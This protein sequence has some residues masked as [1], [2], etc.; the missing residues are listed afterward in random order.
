MKLQRHGTI[1]CLALATALAVSACGSD[2]NE[3]SSGASASAS[4]AADCATGTLNAQGSSAQKNA[5][6]EW[7]KAYQQRC[8][9]STINYEPSGSGAGIQA[10]I[11]GTADF[12]GSDSALKPEEQPQADAKCPGG[13]AIHLPMVIGPVAVAYNLSGVDNL[14][15]KPS[16]LAKIFAGTITKW[17]DAAIKADNPG[18]TLPS[19]AIQTVHRSDESGTT[20]N[21]TKFLASTAASDW[22]FG[23][24]KAWKAPGGTGAKGSD[25]VA[26]AVKQADGAIGYMEW[27]FAENGG[28]K[29]AKIGNGAGE[30]AALTAESAGKAIAG[31]QVTGQGN[32]LKMTIDYNTKEAG[33]YPIVL[34]TY[35]IVCSKGLSADKLALVK[36]FLGYAASAEGQAALTDLGYAPLPESVRSKVESAIQAIA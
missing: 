21:F 20:D 25:G 30:Y 36:G 4:S 16:T 34:V 2:N 17:D 10:F 24:A 5:I 27:S 7:R 26:S 23:N 13:A 22:T 15:L 31:A 1:A 3:P 29:M 32:D 11:A 28:L 33:A 6:D 35:E 12:A 14:Q 9:G 19:T 18:V 8:A